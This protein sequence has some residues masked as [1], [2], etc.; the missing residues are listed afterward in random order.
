MS[1]EKAAEKLYPDDITGAG[2]SPAAKWRD[3]MDHSEAEYPKSST[4]VAAELMRTAGFGVLNQL[5]EHGVSDAE[6]LSRNL[7]AL[8]EDGTADLFTVAGG[9]AQEAMGT[10]DLPYKHEQHKLA[11]LAEAA[12]ATAAATTVYA[13]QGRELAGPTT[14]IAR[15]MVEEGYLNA[16]LSPAAHD[17]LS[18]MVKDLEGPN[19]QG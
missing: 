7:A 9:Y 13:F 11:V 8:P 1:I 17:A 16:E 10:D 3:V 4:V 2:K 18:A 19:P 6:A 12:A 14:S 15:S 5:Y